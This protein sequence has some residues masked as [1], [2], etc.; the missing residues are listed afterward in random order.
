MFEFDNVPNLATY[1][2]CGKCEKHLIMHDEIMVSLSGGADS[3]IVLDFIQ[4]VLKERNFECT[5]RVHYVFFDTGIEYQA[6]KRHL[7]ELENKYGI[8]IERVKGKKPIPTVCKEYGLPFLS[9]DISAK[10]NSLQNNNFDFA[11]DG[12]KDY[13]E[14]QQKYPKCKS[15]LKWW[16]NTKS[17]FNIEQVLYLK[18]FLIENP[19]TFKISSRCC[20]FS[21]K[22]PSKNYEKQNNIDLKILGLRKV[23]GGVR[24]TAYHSCFSP[25]DEK[26]IA[27]FRPIWWFTDK[28]K[29]EYKDFYGLKYSD[30]Y[31]LWGFS[32]TGCA[33]CPFN[34]NFEKDL[35]TIEK[36]EP[37]LYKAVN[38]IFGQSY[39]YTRKYREYK[40]KKQYGGQLTLFDFMND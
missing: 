37:K 38:N 24:S 3:D 34:S 27:N 32:R 8:T 17:N 9:K 11:N 28:E 21:K 2:A 18:Q 23:E 26:H 14:L 39:E 29:S 25:S 4:K 7:D 36:Y 1:E 10:I 15:V 5:C 6:T 16:C 22:M 19:P 12:N 40:T 20:D 33:G 31:E 35:L 30:C 13:E